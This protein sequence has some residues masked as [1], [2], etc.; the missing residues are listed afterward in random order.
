MPEWEY[1]PAEEARRWGN[2]TNFIAD[3]EN[4]F[5]P[6]PAPGLAAAIP[7]APRPPGPEALEVSSSVLHLLGI[8]KNAP[9]TDG[10]LFFLRK[11]INSVFRNAAEW[12]TVNGFPGLTYKGNPVDRLSGKMGRAP[13][14]L[15]D[16]AFS[17]LRKTPLRTPN[18][19]NATLQAISTKLN[20]Q[21]DEAH[22]RKLSQNLP[23]DQIK[24]GMDPT[25]GPDL[26]AAFSTMSTTIKDGLEVGWTPMQIMCVMLNGVI[27]N[28]AGAPHTYNYLGRQTVDAN[29][30]IGN[31]SLVQKYFPVNNP[32]S[33]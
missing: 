5:R 2:L 6:P 21:I 17:L 24:A 13:S 11:N 33:P 19:Q 23:I 32:P 10:D 20:A 12:L 7:V 29:G 18:S 9:M 15:K 3:I 31:P 25:L 16:A 22:S 4:S 26:D 27:N 8:N 30:P 1:D 14:A 28:P